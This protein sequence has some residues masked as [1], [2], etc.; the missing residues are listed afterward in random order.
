MSTPLDAAAEAAARLRSA[1]GRL[2]AEQAQAAR[3]TSLTQR[4]QSELENLE[5]ISNKHMTVHGEFM[6]NGAGE[7]VNEVL[8]PK[9]VVFTEKPICSALGEMRDWNRDMEVILVGAGKF[10]TISTVIVGWIIEDNVANN[11]R[12]YKG[13][14]M[15]CVI[16]G[17]AHMKMIV[18]WTADGMGMG[19]PTSYEPAP[20]VSL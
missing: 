6:L 3:F 17:W 11:L 13:F 19:G 16:S 18:H 5:A 1:Q 7:S 20:I 14:R 2:A 8:F 10:P 9:D 4:R 12:L 15:A